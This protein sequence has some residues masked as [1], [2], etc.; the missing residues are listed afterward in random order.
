GGRMGMRGV[1]SGP[2][3]SMEADATSELPRC[4][5]PPPRFL[6]ATTPGG[7]QLHALPVTGE[8]IIGRD[9]ECAVVLDFDSISR[10]HAHL[11]IGDPCILTALGS[12]NGTRLLG[13]QLGHGD[14]RPIDYGQMFSLGP[15]SL[16]LVPP[17]HSVA[18]MR[19]TG[20]RLRIND[21]ESNA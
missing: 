18:T 7:V 4:A 12:R 17:S 14:A 19:I 21:V 6:L 8:A 1:V 13:E 5:I 15:V 9:P 11:R 16:L 20:S 10:R 2:V 3:S